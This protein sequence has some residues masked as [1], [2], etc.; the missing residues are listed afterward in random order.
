MNLELLKKLAEAEDPC[1]TLMLPVSALVDLRPQIKNAVRDVKKALEGT[2]TDTNALLGPIEVFGSEG[3]PPSQRQAGT[4]VFLRSPSLFEAFFSP[5]LA[6]A[7]TTTGKNFPFLRILPLLKHEVEFYLLA[8]SQKH[9]RLLHCTTHDSAPVDLPAGTP[10]SLAEAMQTR[11]PDHVLDNRSSAGPSV[12]SMKGVMFGTASDRDA[13]DEY[14]LHFFQEIDKAIG[15]LLRERG[16]PLIVAAVENELALYARVNTYADLVEPGVPGAPDGL[17]GGEMHSRALALLQSRIAPPVRKAL[18]QFDKFVGS[19]HAS[20]QGQE[21]A[22]AAAE[23]R[24]SQLF[25]QESAEFKSYVEGEE[26]DLLNEAIIQVIRNGGV[27]SVM[28]SE[29]MPGGAQICALF[30]YPVPKSAGV[31]NAATSVEGD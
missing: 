4:W 21:V 12:G 16:Q 31:A 13:K 1:V 6:H 10:V 22:D 7:L 11:Q 3:V 29:N 30:R 25:L 9:T 18:D 15:R 26:R 20:M 14:L 19:G 17:K 2:G 23:G 28:K 8:L 24:V 27:V 5:V